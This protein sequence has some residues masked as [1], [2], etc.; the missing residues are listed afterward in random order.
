M[1]SNE[2]NKG[3]LTNCVWL[4]APEL[5]NHWH[6]CDQIPISIFMKHSPHPKS[7]C[8]FWSIHEACLYDNY[9]EHKENKLV[10][11]QALHNL[12]HYHL[13]NISAIFP[14]PW[15]RSRPSIFNKFEDHR[16][17]HLSINFHDSER[18]I[19]MWTYV[20]AILRKPDPV[21]DL[22]VKE[23]DWLVKVLDSNTLHISN[24][25]DNFGYNVQFFR[26][27]VNGYSREMWLISS[28]TNVISIQPGW[29]YSKY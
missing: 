27:C 3:R 25:F 21:L 15:W 6:T 13:A 17:W 9:L 5:H 28:K 2:C 18:N 29:K 24:R 16:K 12:R 23:V 14:W 20:M 1:R 11:T 8:Q 7:K 4:K 26:H 10:T 22:Q 19:Q